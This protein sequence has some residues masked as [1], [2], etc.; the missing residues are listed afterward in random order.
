MDAVPRVRVHD[1]TAAK[2]LRNRGYASLQNRSCAC[3]TAGSSPTKKDMTGIIAN[4]RYSDKH[5]EGTQDIGFILIL[6]GAV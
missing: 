4:G 2:I 6:A 3:R 5:A 1:L